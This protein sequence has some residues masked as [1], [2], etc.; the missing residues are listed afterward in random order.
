MGA[1][2]VMDIKFGTPEDRVKFENKYNLKQRDILVGEKSNSMGFMAWTVLRDV[3]LNV[4][5]FMGFMGYAEPEEILKECLKEGIKIKF[6][7]WI[8]INDKD[9]RWEK[10]RGKW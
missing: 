3:Y 6:L 5:Y 2:I 7:A 9:S 10:I 8:P 1:F 4:V